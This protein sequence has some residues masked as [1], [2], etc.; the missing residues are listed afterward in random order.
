MISW[1]WNGPWLYVD[2]L[3]VVIS[4]YIGVR[5]VIGSPCGNCTYKLNKQILLLGQGKWSFIWSSHKNRHF[6][7]VHKKLWWLIME[8]IFIS[9]VH[10]RDTNSWPWIFYPT[11][12]IYFP[13]DNDP[14]FVNLN[15]VLLT[16]LIMETEYS[17]FGC[18]YHACWC[19]G[20]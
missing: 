9:L 10:Q 4:Y 1:Y 18:Q 5:I 15:P 12:F 13:V 17:G 8:M 16:L 14:C 11:I 6:S 7:N 3:Y 19:T 20:S 2:V